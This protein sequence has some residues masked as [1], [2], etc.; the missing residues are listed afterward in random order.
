MISAS[1][2]LKTRYAG[3]VWVLMAT[4]LVSSARIAAG[5]P[6]D[7]ELVDE[8]PVL[9]PEFEVSD[10]AVYGRVFGEGADRSAGCEQLNTL[11]RQKIAI[12]DRVC[13]LTS[14]QKQKLQLASLG[15]ATRLFNRVDKI[16][17]RIQLVRDDREQVYQLLDEAHSLQ[18]ELIRPGLSNDG[19]LFFKSLERLLTDEQAV[20]FAPLRAI[21]CT[22]GLLRIRRDGARELVEINLTGTGFFDD[23][24]ARLRELP[25]LHVLVLSQ[26]QVT[27]QGLAHLAGL[28]SLHA[29]FLN[30]TRVTDGG[31]AEIKGLTGLRELALDGL[32]ITDAGLEHLQRLTGL[33]SLSLKATGVSD[34]GLGYLKGLTK[35]ESLVLDETEV[36]DAGLAHL[37]GLAS[38][39][40][41]LVRRTSVTNSGVAELHR[42]LPRLAIHK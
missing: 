19:S 31:L 9:E 42:I 6:A 41:L 32:P 28:T 24:L 40:L 11:L 35:L 3:P 16:A 20:K 33:Q 1:C 23:E 30:Q 15:D 4:F 17:A 29:L 13:G 5:D 14:T 25:G 37:K 38:L 27:D 12:V 18:H 7:D 2:R 10:A 21:V 8:S 34:A 26:S 39:E 22:G 36:T